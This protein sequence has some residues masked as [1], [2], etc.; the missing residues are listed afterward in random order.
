MC[1][2]MISKVPAFV[3]SLTEVDLSVHYLEWTAHV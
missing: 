3:D 2:F 1:F